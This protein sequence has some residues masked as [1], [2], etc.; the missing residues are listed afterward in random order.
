MSFSQRV[1]E[2]TA[3]IIP[4]AR[5]CALAELAAV[6]TTSG[7]FYPEEGRTMIGIRTENV[8]VAKAS[9]S[10][11]KKLFG[12]SSR[13]SVKDR[14]Q[15]HR[16]H[17]YTITLADAAGAGKMIRA[18]KLEDAVKRMDMSVTS[19]DRNLL[20][21][22]CCRKAFL[23]GVFLSA[24]SLSDPEKIYHLELVAEN[25]EFAREIC[26]VMATFGLNAKTV[27][28]KGRSVVYLKEG[29]QIVDFLGLIQ[30]NVSLLNFENTR[31]MKDVRNNVNRS[32]NCETANL[33]K[34]VTAGLKELRDIEKIDRLFGLEALP[35]PL[36]EA[37]YARLQYPDVSLKELG[38]R[39]DPP[40]GKSG[41]NH[42]MR[43]IHEIA[44]EEKL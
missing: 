36:R 14:N 7:F 26:D 27:E 18:L 32:V 31:V 21:S 33:G 44:E 12:T 10:L 38:E 17:L 1:K 25:A 16:G 34:T 22:E 6:F 24:G 20:Q 13:V 19:A 42:R 4:E 29:N 35:G 28:R 11:I 3:K 39:F 23:R 2:E 15:I 5:H 8:L 37:A 43:R 40:V 30:A 41:V 9:F